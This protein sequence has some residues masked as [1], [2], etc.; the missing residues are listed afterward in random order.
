MRLG[1]RFLRSAR[2]LRR[3][4]FQRIQREGIRIRTS[5][6]T[7][8]ARASLTGQARLGLAVSRKVGPAVVRN[9]IKRLLRELFRRTA[10]SL[11][12]VDFIV[13]AQADA[14]RLAAAGLAAMA[15]V[16]LPAWSRAAERAS[17]KGRR[18]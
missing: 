1:G 4:E 6:F 14:P 16:A 9:R 10:A 7:V 18:R 12:A 5:A 11:P 8:V 2:I 3:W 17:A 13:I 15:E